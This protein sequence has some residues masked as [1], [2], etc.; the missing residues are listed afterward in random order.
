MGGRYPFYLLD[1]TSEGQLNEA[2][3]T[4]ST[5]SS[6]PTRGN[7]SQGFVY[8]RVPHITLKSI[9]NN[10]EIDVIWD[11][12]QQA[13]EPLRKSLNKA[14]GKHWQ[15]WEIPRE[16]D[17]KWSAEA[18]QLHADWWQ[19]R[20]A[21]QRETDASITAKADNEYPYDKPYETKKKARAT[22]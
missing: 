2:E 7:L 1:D 11:K 6:A 22:K 21:C 10:T 12:F 15:V 5:P 13:L 3:H 8:E 18:K 19:Q 14:L 9:A 20:I 16:V 17:T 4:R